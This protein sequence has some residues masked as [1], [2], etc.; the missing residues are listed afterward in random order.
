MSFI[1]LK[2]LIVYNSKNFNNRRA[3]SGI[4]V[5]PHHLNPGNLQ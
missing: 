3:V 1:S 5:L 4:I 2:Y